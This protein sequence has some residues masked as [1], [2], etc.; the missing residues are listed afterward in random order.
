MSVPKFYERVEQFSY[1]LT[2]LKNFTKGHPE[3]FSKYTSYDFNH[4]S[5]TSQ[6]YNVFNLLLY[7][8]SRVAVM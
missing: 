3:H 8:P 6:V 7:R 1:K 5:F 2:Q 4:Q